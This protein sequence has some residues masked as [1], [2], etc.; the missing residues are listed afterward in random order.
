MKHRSPGDVLN[1]VWGYPSFRPLQEPII[2]SVLEGRD[3]LALLP[4]GGGKSVCYQVPALC[5]GRLALVISPLIALMQDQ[6]QQL[7]ERGVRAKALHSGLQRKEIEGILKLAVQGD[8]DFLYLAPE[9]LKTDLFLGHLEHMS[10]SLVAVDEAHC[11]SQ[12][13]HEFR[14]SYREIADIRPYLHNVPFLAVTATATEKV[15]RDITAQLQMDN[16]GRFSA[17]FQRENLKW[18]VTE[19]SYAMHRLLHIVKSVGGTQIIYTQSRFRTSEIAHFLQQRGQKALFYHAGLSAREREERQHQWM[20]GQ[21]PIMV[22][23]NAFGMGVD[24]SDVRAVIHVDLPASPEAYYQE[25][26]RAGRDGKTSYAV[27]IYDQA[28]L[29]RMDERIEQMY[30]ELEFCRDVGR[31]LYRWYKVAVGA[32]QYSS[33][34]FDIEKFSQEYDYSVIKV[35]HALRILELSAWVERS[36]G[37]IVPSRLHV[38][39]NREDL[40]RMQLAD[41]QFDIFMKT[42]LRS[43]EGLF[44]DFVNIREWQM[45]KALEISV[46]EVI[47]YLHRLHR[48]DIIT[49]FPTEGGERI[50]FLQPRSP[51][52]VIYIN[53][54]IRRENYKR[55][56]DRWR[57]M[58][59][60]IFAEK[61]RSQ[62]LLR[63]FGEAITE[64]CG[65]CDICM[66]SRKGQFSDPKLQHKIKQS[67]IHQ[68]ESRSLSVR[69]WTYQYPVTYKKRLLSL[70]GDLEAENI[71]QINSQMEMSLNHD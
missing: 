64:E 49:Y 43:Y 27:L 44:M 28:A 22:S 67:L 5:M 37:L 70:L 6:V 33:F 40:Y 42:L 31:N 55:A 62:V 66:G 48:K 47:A 56:T 54:K 36:E 29:E 46:D 59:E 9:R 57:A 25:A 53:P 13:G 52:G 39:C 3:T 10:L 17:S 2:S 69:E 35:Y 21:V 41:P 63:Y 30:P 4:T 71:I 24:K 65:N 15:S 38:K 11:I 8:L 19:D 60:Y 68:L 50:T 12:W 23:T 18:I 1:E 34:P 26:G 16:P 58:K 45:A 51:R 32:G 14:P 20:S 61:C 7:H